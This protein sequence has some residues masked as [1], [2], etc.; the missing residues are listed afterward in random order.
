MIGA[1]YIIQKL[2]YDR[3]TGRLPI[4]AGPGLSFMLQAFTLSDLEVLPQVLN[5]FQSME[6]R[7]SIQ[8]SGNL[9]AEGGNNLVSDCLLTRAGI[10]QLIFMQ[11][12]Q[13]T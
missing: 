13:G 6:V 11:L 8:S 10:H 5:D 9:C 1:K 4:L 3:L 7:L 2:S 12:D